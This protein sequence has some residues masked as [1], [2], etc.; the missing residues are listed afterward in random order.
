[1]LRKIV[2]ELDVAVVEIVGLKIHKI[3]NIKFLVE[4][5]QGK[6][7]GKKITKQKRLQF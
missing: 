6:G 3:F 7:D 5:K 2:V 1:M 4:W